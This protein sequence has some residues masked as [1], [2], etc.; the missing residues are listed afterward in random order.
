MISEKREGWQTK[1][2]ERGRG[3]GEAAERQV[4]FSH[5]TEEKFCHVKETKEEE[6]RER[7]RERETRKRRERSRGSGEEEGRKESE[8]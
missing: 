7:E 1:R 2:E 6:R 8:R 3:R 4:E 5:T